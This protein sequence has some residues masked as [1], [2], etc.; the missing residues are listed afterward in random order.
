MCNRLPRKGLPQNQPE[1]RQITGGH[2]KDEITLS[3]LVRRG[4]AASDP[5]R[6][7]RQYLQTM[8]AQK[9]RDP[10][11]AVIGAPSGDRQ[12]RAA[13]RSA[14]R[15]RPRNRKPAARMRLRQLL[16]VRHGHQTPR[17]CPNQRQNHAQPQRPSPGRRSKGLPEK[18]NR[19]HQ[20]RQ[21]DAGDAHPHHS[22]DRTIKSRGNVEVAGGAPR[23][24]HVDQRDLNAQAAAKTTSSAR[25]NRGQMR[26][27][28]IQ[29]AKLQAAIM[30]ESAN[31]AG[32]S[33][34]GAPVITRRSTT[35]PDKAEHQVSGHDEPQHGQR[36]RCSKTL[37]TALSTASSR[38]AKA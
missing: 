8:H 13:I 38:F 1:K 9:V 4:A 21:P 14:H 25:V 10:Q 35:S 18:N 33:H 34:A 37:A 15:V 20:H 17:A 31:F 36:G 6:Q 24:L 30:V 12:S 29:K 2:G 16:G 23:R 27:D 5:P 28:A 7:Q 26:V 19:E 32:L 22:K 3:P 11:I